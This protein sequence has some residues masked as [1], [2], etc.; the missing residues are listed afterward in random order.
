MCAAAVSVGEAI[1]YV[2]AGTVEFILDADKNFYFLEVNTRL[3]VEHPVTEMV[4]GQDLVRWQIEVAQG[5]HLPPFANRYGHAIEVRVYAEDPQNDFLPVTGT[6][7]RWR[8]SA[9]DHLANSKRV[10]A[11]SKVI[12]DSGVRSGDTVSVHYDPMLAKVIAHGDTREDAI[13]RLDYALAQLQLLG[14]RNNIAFLRHILN[15]PEFIAGNIDTGF[16]DRHPDLLAEISDVPLVALV[17]AAAAKEGIPSPPAPLP[18]GEGRNQ[19]TLKV[20][21]PKGRGD[22]GVRASGH[23]RNNPYRP[24]R[25]QFTAGTTTYTVNLTP[26]G[27]NSYR[28]QVG[29]VSH[30]AQIELLGEA[31]YAV[32]LDGH[33]QRVTALPDEADNWWVHTPAGTFSLAWVSPLPAGAR[34]AEAEGSLRAPMPG[35]VIA[36]HVTDGQSV[37]KGDILLVIEAMKMEHRIKAPYNGRIASIYYRVG[38]SV[39]AGAALL[40]LHPSENT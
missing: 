35:S 37:T 40:E 16:I 29:E 28:V 20:L 22:L 3:Q 10:W 8:E 27:H 33:R 34:A 23:W 9:T 14:L 13:R 32:T 12:F 19:L 24:I 6:I 1:G 11:W 4:M 5:G 21:S 30:E 25:H 2:N 18:Q 17:A 15:H 36:I 26:T 39:E 7:L 31:A 38:Q